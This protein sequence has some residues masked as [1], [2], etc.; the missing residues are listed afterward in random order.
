MSGAARTTDAR[1]K[2]S[3]DSQAVAPVVL[4][5]HG[6][7]GVGKDSVIDLL[8]ERTGIHRPTSS[9]SRLPREGEVDGVDY[10]F[11]TRDEFVD[12]IAEGRFLEWAA[13]YNDFKGVESAEITAPLAEGRDIIIRTDVQGARTWRDKLDGAVFVFLMAEDRDALRARL[14]NRGS[15]DGD[16]LAARLEELEAELADIPNNDHLVINH[17]GRLEEA[18]D[19]I[20][21]II[22]AE[23]AKPNRKAPRLR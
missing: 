17:H 3:R 19:Q 15:E 11:L 10:H 5:L 4:V 21:A 1:A 7:S 8:R 18:V 2:R 14:I 20:I 6:P 16:S 12:R 22:E 13:V 23:R 9:T